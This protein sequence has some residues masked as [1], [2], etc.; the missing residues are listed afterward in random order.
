M[1]QELFLACALALPITSI[2]HF[3]RSD[4]GAF[5]KKEFLK[6]YKWLIEMLEKM[7]PGNEF[8]IMPVQYEETPPGWIWVPMGWRGHLLYRRE[9]QSA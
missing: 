7:Y 8:L 2:H 1:I 5:T 4:S 6:E 9:K 3:D